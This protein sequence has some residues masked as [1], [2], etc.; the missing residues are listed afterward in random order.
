MYTHAKIPVIG[1][2]PKLAGQLD[3][4]RN[5]ESCTAVIYLATVLDIILSGVA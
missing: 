4:S 5:T 2:L 1:N 3:N